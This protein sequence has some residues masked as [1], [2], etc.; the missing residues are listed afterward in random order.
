MARKIIDL[1]LTFHNAA[2]GVNIEPALRIKSDGFNTSNLHIY[3]HALTHMDAPLHFLENGQPIDELNL[4]KCVGK[5]IVVDMSHKLPNSLITVEDMQPYVDRI[6]P[7]SRVLI[8]T[9]WDTHAG[10]DDYRT[11]FPRISV[12]LAQWLATRGVWLLGVETP[13]V[14]SLR[15]ERRQELTEVHQILLRADIVIVESLANLAQIQC[16]EVYFIALPLKLN[17]CDGSPTR[18][19]VIIEEEDGN[20]L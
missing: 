9:D 12:E 16:D 10:L 8:R 4:Q 15:L 11:D 19:I 17:Q 13:S 2:Q 14:A 3:S 1:S 18:P 20:K 5:A 6:Q 7:Q